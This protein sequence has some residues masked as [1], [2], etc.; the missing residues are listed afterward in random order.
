MFE[1][2]QI[3]G[4]NE[5]PYAVRA[6]SLDAQLLKQMHIRSIAPGTVDVREAKK[7]AAKSKK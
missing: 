1:L 4:E 5:I 6:K 3:I 2:V 7:P